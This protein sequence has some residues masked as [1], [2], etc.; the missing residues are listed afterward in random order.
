MVAIARHLLSPWGRILGGFS[1]RINKI[2]KGITQI[3]L[4]SRLTRVNGMWVSLYLVGGVLIDAGF[5]HGRE[6]L[7]KVLSK[8]TLRAI[9]LTHHHEDHSGISGTLSV[10]HGCPIYLR[11]ISSRFDEGVAPYK[12]Y[13]LIWW[14]AADHYQ[15]LEMPERIVADDRTLLVV[16]ISGHSSTHTAFFDERN[17]DVFVGDLFMNKGAAAVMSHENPFE[18]VRSLR[19][20]ACLMPLRMLTGHGLV[21][22][23]PVALLREKADIIERT[24]E[25]IVQLNNAGLSPRAIVARVFPRG[26]LK[27]RVIEIFTGGQFSRINF[28]RACIHFSDK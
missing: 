18:S 19:R 24:A 10:L 25:K 14:G 27:D 13:R 20:V 6:P 17:G 3:C 16:P 9:C 11:N 2:P 26:F 7:L 12:P 23:H 21:I 4:S 22:D 28:V 8:V 1:C 5:V 15:P